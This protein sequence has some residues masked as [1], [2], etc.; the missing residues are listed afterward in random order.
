MNNLDIHPKSSQLLLLNGCLW[1][2]T[3]YKDMKGV[4]NAKIGVVW[5]LGV[6]Q[7]H[8]QRNHS[9]DRIRLPLQL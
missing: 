6:P 5:G 1:S 7:G 3:H 9:I 8:R 2:V 4:E